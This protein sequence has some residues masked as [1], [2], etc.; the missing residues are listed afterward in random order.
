MTATTADVLANRA[1]WSCVA[2]DAVAFLD[3]LPESAGITGG[4]VCAATGIGDAGPVWRS[5]VAS[6]D[7]ARDLV[8]L[9]PLYQPA[10]PRR[11]LRRFRTQPL[12]QATQRTITP[13]SPLKT[14]NLTS[15][16]TDFN[17]P[18]EPDETT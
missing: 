11:T 4:V 18:N 14:P 12:R 17:P 16:T 13:H 8:G 6:T 15:N 1:P 9:A 2:S 5:G 3:S 7:Y 10:S